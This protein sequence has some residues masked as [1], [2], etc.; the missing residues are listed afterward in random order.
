MTGLSRVGERSLLW[1][2]QVTSSGEQQNHG[3][4]SCGFGR[5]LAQEVD[6]LTAV[7]WALPPDA[8]PPLPYVA[9]E[10]P[11]AAPAV[12]WDMAGYRLQPLSPTASEVAAEEAKMGELG[13]QEPVV[14]FLAFR[15]NKR[16]IGDIL[17][18]RNRSARTRRTHCEL[19]GVTNR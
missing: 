15:M 18:C 1:L 12:G 6:P 16:S 11:S 13:P 14:S 10:A 19:P 8:L 7:S 4:R 2:R 5:S 3:W 9:L 17:Q